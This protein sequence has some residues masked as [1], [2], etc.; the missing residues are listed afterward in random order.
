MKN[1]S[2]VLYKFSNTAI[3]FFMVISFLFALRRR[4]L[5]HKFHS[6]GVIYLFAAE[7]DGKRVV[8][9]TAA[10]TFAAQYTLG[11]GDVDGTDVALSLTDG[12]NG[13]DTLPYLEMIKR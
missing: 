4:V 9:G 10:D 12:K 5:L 7:G 8:L 1:F 13:F 11:G 2:N 6:V 3:S